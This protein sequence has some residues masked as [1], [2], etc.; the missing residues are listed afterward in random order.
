MVMEESKVTK[1]TTLSYE[2]S[3]LNY[4]DWCKSVMNEHI[5]DKT[6]TR[7]VG[8]YT[9]ASKTHG[10]TIVCPECNK[11]ATVFHFAW[12]ALG[13]QHCGTMVDKYEWKLL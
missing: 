9:R 7:K 12:S 6:L 1:M 5:K 11:V 8:K 10:K 13:C 2:A 4:I 3:G